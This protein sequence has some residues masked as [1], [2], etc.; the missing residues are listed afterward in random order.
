MPAAH[1]TNS[2]RCHSRDE[3]GV[4][5]PRTTATTH[6]R[7]KKQTLILNQDPRSIPTS[8][9]MDYPRP[10][11][12]PKRQRQRCGAPAPALEAS[13]SY[14][15]VRDTPRDLLVFYCNPKREPLSGL[16]KEAHDC[17]EAFPRGADVR[18]KRNLDPEELREELLARPPRAFL[19]L[20]HANAALNGKPTLA[21][22][23]RDGDLVTVKPDVLARMLGAFSPAQGGP[24]ELVFLNGCESVALG[25]A[26]HKAGVPFVVRRP[27]THRQGSRSARSTHCHS[28]VGKPVA[29]RRIATQVCWETLVE[30]GAA[31]TFSRAFF[32]ASAKH[33]CTYEAAFEQVRRGCGGAM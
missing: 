9:M 15:G 4:A 18:Q 33:G 30:N 21:F 10:P 26:V 32:R 31:A 27:L 8:I 6:D 20:G 13:P 12:S 28:P 17:Q 25:E 14:R 5:H 11:K 16:D 1:I 23:N 3:C 22:T 7:K 29:A 19:F 2:R 24:L